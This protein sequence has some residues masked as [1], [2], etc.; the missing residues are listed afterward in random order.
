M[1]KKGFTYIEVMI[2]LAI[3]SLMLIFV[4]KLS[5][6][7]SRFVG[8][9]KQKMQMMYAGQR[10]IEQYKTLLFKN[11]DVTNGFTTTTSEGFTVKVTDTPGTS[12]TKRITVIDGTGTT[13]TNYAVN[14]VTAEV[15][16]QDGEYTVYI[17]DIF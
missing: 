11:P 12:N 15:T 1:K 2:A 10:A 3:F 14:E 6:S 16:S 17:R 5:S 9:E 13:L 7:T 8:Y 4:M